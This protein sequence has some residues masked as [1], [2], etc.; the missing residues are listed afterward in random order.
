MTISLG[1]MMQIGELIAAF[2]VVVSVAFVVIEIRQNSEAQIQSTTQE[3][4]SNYINSL[5]RLV[6]NPDFTC[7]Y[8]RGAQ[9]YRELR[10]DERLRFSAY[11]MSTYY[12]LQEM[13]RLADEGSIDADTW[14][15]FQSLLTETTRYPGVRQWFSDRREWFS[16]HFQSHIDNLIQSH[17]P[18]DSYLFNDDSNQACD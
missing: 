4:V 6:D 12:Q 9:N 2:A 18:I 5:E 10:G 1:R 11:Y 7:L 15:G 17:E 3:A 16:A 13:L 14:S 8:I